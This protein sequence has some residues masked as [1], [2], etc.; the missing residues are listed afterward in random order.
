MLT[1]EPRSY[2][3]ITTFKK[4]TAS[5][6]GPV[7]WNLQEGPYLATFDHD[8]N[9]DEVNDLLRRLDDYA[10]RIVIS[11]VPAGTLGRIKN[12]V[13]CTWTFYHTLAEL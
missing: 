9:Q 7:P 4:S 5:W 10:D 3:A 12:P 6:G 11:F 2:H 8:P 13:C 1:Q